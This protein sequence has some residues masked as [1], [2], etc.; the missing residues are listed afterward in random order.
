MTELRAD[1]GKC[2]G[3]CCV[4][5]AFAAS[6]DFAVSKPAG[7]PCLNL[8]S[9]NRCGIHDSLRAKGFAG[10][11]AY[12]C[13]GAGQRITQEVFPGRDW[14]STPDVAGAMFAAFDVLRDL[15]EILW[16]LTEAAR[17]A[18]KSFH[19]ELTTARAETERIARQPPERLAAADVA[20]HRGQ[21]AELL[22]RVSAALR[23][24]G[25]RH[26]GAD[27]VGRDLRGADL[28]RADLRG[29]YLIGADLT[30]ADLSGADL[31]GADL[32]GANLAGTTLSTA[33]FLTQMQVN[34][35]TGDTA[36]HLP[37][38]LRRPPHWGPGAGQAGS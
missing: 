17:R 18:P 26:R 25:P 37:P 30:R 10:C 33:L 20:P 6:T 27:L 14:R 24:R 29:A 34:S 8:L 4:A 31:L 3:L 12:D 38:R 15:H 36:T 11:T 9:D 2:V 19:S 21:V 16:Y 1:C 28:R 7:Q 23:G 35:A 13:F 5:P 22:S 32:R